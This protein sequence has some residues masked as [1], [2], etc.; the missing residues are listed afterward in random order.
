VVRAAKAARK[1]RG[2]KPTAAQL[3]VFPARKYAILPFPILKLPRYHLRLLVL[4]L[5]RL[6]RGAEWL[7]RIERRII[8]CGS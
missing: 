2:F 8:K 6:R 4:R 1:W 7:A 5:R 3:P